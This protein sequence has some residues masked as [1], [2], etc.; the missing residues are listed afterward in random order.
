MCNHQ[1]LQKDWLNYNQPKKLVTI[2]FPETPLLHYIEE[3][4]PSGYGADCTSGRT[5]YQR[6]FIE[7]VR[8][9]TCSMCG[10]VLNGKNTYVLYYIFPRKYKE[11]V[12]CRC[13][14]Y[15]SPKDK[16]MVRKIG[17]VNYGQ[18]KEIDAKI[19]KYTVYRKTLKDYKDEIKDNIRYIGYDTSP[20]SW[21]I[22]KNKEKVHQ[23]KIDL[24]IVES[25]MD[26]IDKVLKKLSDRKNYLLGT[27]VKEPLPKYEIDYNEV[28]PFRSEEDFDF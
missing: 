1:Q 28:V 19:S 21:D 11:E 10:E 26:K 5:L 14:A 17:F 3:S 4:V 9:K 8:G 7:Q 16:K 2:L 27:K 24:E 13:C 18:V 22:N 23:L 15:L 20:Y 6:R 12:Y 25:K